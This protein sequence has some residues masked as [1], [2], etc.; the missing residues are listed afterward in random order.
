M[1]IDIPNDTFS[2]ITKEV[3][4]VISLLTRNSKFYYSNFFF[5]IFL[6]SLSLRNEQI[7]LHCGYYLLLFPDNEENTLDTTAKDN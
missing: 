6:T 3:S 2:S 5:L 4:E 1:I 7:T